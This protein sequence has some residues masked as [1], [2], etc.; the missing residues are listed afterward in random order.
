MIHLKTPLVTLCFTLLG[1]SACTKPTPETPS[2]TNE[3]PQA[4]SANTPAPTPPSAVKPVWP[5][6]F[7][8]DAVTTIELKNTEDHV[9]LTRAGTEW[10][11]PAWQQWPAEQ[12]FVRALLRGVNALES[13]EAVGFYPRE[14]D[15]FG[16]DKPNRIVFSDDQKRSLTVIVGGAG[17]EPRDAFVR[18]DDGPT[19]FKVPAPWVANTHRPTWGSRTVWQVPPDLV[20]RIE[21]TGTDQTPL[22]IVKSE[23]RWLLTAPKDGQLIPKFGMQMLPAFAHFRSQGLRFEPA[24]NFKTRQPVAQLKIAAAEAEMKV[25]F[26]ESKDGQYIEGYRDGYPVVYLFSRNVLTMPKVSLGDL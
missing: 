7:D 12:H 6:D 5:I 14:G 3:P 17:Q 21:W 4:V 18:I 8:V 9:V 13:R 20:H 2:T 10:L 15:L 11:V 1:L 19:I 22:T 26:Y 25:V 16:F 23:N 24:V